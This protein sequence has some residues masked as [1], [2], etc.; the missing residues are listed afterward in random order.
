MVS[1]LVKNCEVF[2]MDPIFL[3]KPPK[4]LS[5]APSPEV[6]T[7]HIDEV[8]PKLVRESIQRSNKRA[9]LD[10]LRREE[11]KNRSIE[12]SKSFSCR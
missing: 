5:S 1:S 10:Y 3:H 11:A 4:E 9:A 7:A 12:F 2:D 8:D 6:C